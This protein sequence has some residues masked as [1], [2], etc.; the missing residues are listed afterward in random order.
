MGVRAG[1]CRS[2]KR[3]RELLKTD[4]RLAGVEKEVMSRVNS[5]P[6]LHS[7]FFRESVL[8]HVK[9]YHV[10]KSEEGNKF[11]TNFLFALFIFPKF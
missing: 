2:I 5:C 7:F 8:P 4:S 11:D 3:H 1:V 9:V 10:V 6:L